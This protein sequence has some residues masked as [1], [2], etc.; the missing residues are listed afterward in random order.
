MR[1]YYVENIAKWPDPAEDARALEGVPD[2][3]REYILRYRFAAD[4]KRSLGVWRLLEQVLAGRGLS[5][6][7]VTLGEHGKP[8]HPEIFFSLSHSADLVMCAVADVPVGCDIEKIVRAP[9]G[10]ADRYFTAGEREYLS[11]ALD[12]RERDR[13]FFQL[14]TMKESYLKMTGEGILAPLES[15]EMNPETGEVRRAGERQSCRVERIPRD[16]YEMAVCVEL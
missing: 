3:R 7:A 14:W 13:R 10:V 5:V 2:W 8:E 16:G 1:E 6:E 9:D 15:L 11:N 12:F 4:R